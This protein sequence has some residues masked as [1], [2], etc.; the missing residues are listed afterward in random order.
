MYH[1]IHLLKNDF[2]NKRFKP[3]HE[4][5]EDRTWKTAKYTT[6]CSVGKLIL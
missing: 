5:I 1:K 6:K 4:N 3:N 2:K